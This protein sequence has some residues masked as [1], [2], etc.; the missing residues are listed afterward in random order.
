[1]STDLSPNFLKALASITACVVFTTCAYAIPIT[2]SISLPGNITATGPQHAQSYAGPTTVTANYTIQRTTDSSGHV[3][4][5]PTGS[6]LTFTDSQFN[7]TTSPI[8]VSN[9]IWDLS[10]NE[11]L[12]FSFS[13]T[14]WIPNANNE[15]VTSNG[16]SGII[17][18]TSKE[19]NFT[20]SYID[21]DTDEVYKYTFSTPEPSILSLLVCAI[22]LMFI[23]RRHLRL[24]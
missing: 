11:I 17:K 4:F 2:G 10:N 18:F 15:G 24:N 13:S 14:D 19:A 8:Q 5:N 21:S 1:M 7:W 3:I 12:A 6:T 16:L 20:A 22:A 9:V 23:T